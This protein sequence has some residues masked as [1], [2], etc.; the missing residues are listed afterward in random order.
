MD[1]EAVEAK[2]RK[3]NAKIAELNKRA[4][5]ALAAPRWRSYA[6]GAVGLG[7][8]G[9]GAAALSAVLF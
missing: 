2:F 5:E 9:L 1:L 6:A 3:I 8:F 4:E 7:V